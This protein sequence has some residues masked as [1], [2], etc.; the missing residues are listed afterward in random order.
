MPY[1]YMILHRD[2]AVEL[3][4]CIHDNMCS[5][6]REGQLWPGETEYRCF[7]QE[8]DCE[9]CRVR[10]IGDIYSAHFTVCQKVSAWEVSKLYQ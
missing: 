3:N 5:N 8:K 1:Y 2:H 4:R 7:T 10:P 9:D 6:P